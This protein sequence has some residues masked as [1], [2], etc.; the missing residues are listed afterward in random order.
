MLF[1]F[2]AVTSFILICCHYTCNTTQRKYALKPQ[3]T[4]WRNILYTNFNRSITNVLLLHLILSA[5]C[6]EL[7]VCVFSNSRLIAKRLWFVCSQLVLSNLIITVCCGQPACL[8][9]PSAH[10]FNGHFCQTKH[11]FKDP[12]K[13]H[14]FLCVLAWSLGMAASCTEMSLGHVRRL[15]ISSRVSIC[16]KYK[17][18]V[19][20]TNVL[21]HRLWPHCFWSRC[22]S[23]RSR[24]ASEVMVSP[25]FSV[26]KRWLKMSLFSHSFDFW[27]LCDLWD[28]VIFCC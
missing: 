10:C 13:L 25:L 18:F 15:L 28:T 16:S 3:L 19:Y 23:A 2:Y 9:L 5:V 26:F 11:V 21:H 22:S 6:V 20:Y 27:C 7:A 14:I 4:W 8:L 17:T 1:N 24:L 12:L